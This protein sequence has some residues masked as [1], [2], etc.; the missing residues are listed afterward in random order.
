M[1][2]TVNLGNPEWAIRIAL[3]PDKVR[4]LGTRFMGPGGLPCFMLRSPYH[5]RK[6]TDRRGLHV[7]NTYM[8]PG[9]HRAESCDRHNTYVS[10]CI[11]GVSTCLRNVAILSQWVP[12]AAAVLT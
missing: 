4:L 5:V 6:V 8:G 10:T 11:P 1:D 2:L 9:A 3:F 12:E 7:L